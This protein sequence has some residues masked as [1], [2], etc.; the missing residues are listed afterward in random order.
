[1]GTATGAAAILAIPVGGLAAITPAGAA[2][3]SRI[4]VR[5][6]DDQFLLRTRG[7]WMLR[8][9]SP[10]SI[11]ARNMFPGN[12]LH[13]T[14]VIAMASF[15]R[16]VALKMLSAAASFMLCLIMVSVSLSLK[17][18]AHRSAGSGCCRA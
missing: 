6:F 13:W 11:A 3:V 10:R 12:S 8:S 14:W 2:V 18:I 5:I 15:A 16:T 7:V 1:M 9:Q 17:R 4:A